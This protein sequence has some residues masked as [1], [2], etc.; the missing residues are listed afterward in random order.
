MS[1]KTT[2]IMALFSFTSLFANAQRL[3]AKQIDKAERITYWFNNGTVAPEHQQTVTYSVTADSITQKVAGHDG[4]T[5]KTLAVSEADQQLF[6]EQ[7]KKQD[8]KC[9]KKSAPNLCTGGHDIGLGLYADSTT[10]FYA[11]AYVG[12][13]RMGGKLACNEMDVCHCFEQLF[14]SCKGEEE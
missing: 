1:I 9:L 13:G 7:L 6:R 2:I 11:S 14:K 12:G 8:I 4:T 10:L 3:T 5:I